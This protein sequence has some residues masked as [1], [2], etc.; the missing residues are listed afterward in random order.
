MS[1]SKNLVDIELHDHVKRLLR[2]RNITFSSIAKCLG[3][4][5]SLITMVSQGHRRNAFVEDMIASKAGVAPDELWRRRSDTRGSR[6]STRKEIA[7]PK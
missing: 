7:M 3:C 4:S 5:T 2:A 1:R 6:P